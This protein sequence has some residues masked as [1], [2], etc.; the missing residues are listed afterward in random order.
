MGTY[1]SPLRLLW[2][3]KRC[4]IKASEND[5]DEY[6]LEGEIPMF[7]NAQTQLAMDVLSDL[8]APSP[9]GSLKRGLQKMRSTLNVK[10]M[11]WPKPKGS[12][13]RTFADREM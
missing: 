5:D 12:K 11:T 4:L 1:A 10:S 2:A 13:K 7:G 8:M 6:S 3:K 9:K